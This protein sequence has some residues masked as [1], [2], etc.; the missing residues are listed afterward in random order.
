MLWIDPWEVAIILVQKL[1]QHEQW[2]D[3]P[4]Y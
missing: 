2:Q 3:G 1:G 4:P